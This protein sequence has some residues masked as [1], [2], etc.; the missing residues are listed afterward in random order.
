VHRPT[1][2]QALAGKLS[3]IA[4]MVMFPPLLAVLVSLCIPRTPVKTLAVV[5]LCF[6]GAGF[7]LVKLC[8]YLSA[9]VSSWLTAVAWSSVVRAD[10]TDFRRL[11][12]MLPTVTRGLRRSSISAGTRKYQRSQQPG[13]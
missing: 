3:N 12:L 10:R 9:A 4:G 5:A 1:V 8:G 7:S 13:P 2:R 6:T 11:L